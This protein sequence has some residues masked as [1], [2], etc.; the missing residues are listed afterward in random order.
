M[1]IVL[2]YLIKPIHVQ[3]TII[4]YIWRVYSVASYKISYY[5]AISIYDNFIY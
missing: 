4:I 2:L 1:L 5:V 3:T